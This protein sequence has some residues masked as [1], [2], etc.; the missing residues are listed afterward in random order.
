MNLALMIIFCTSAVV[1]VVNYFKVGD[2]VA[3]FVKEK[4]RRT[5]QESIPSNTSKTPTN[6]AKQ[7]YSLCQ[8]S[9]L[10]GFVHLCYKKR[11]KIF[12]PIISNCFI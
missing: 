8:D 11:K 1:I 6:E 4:V 7:N 3:A 10:D 12:L 5:L 9:S 2:I